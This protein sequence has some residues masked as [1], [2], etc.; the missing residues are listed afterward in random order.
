MGAVIP[1]HAI[2]IM[3]AARGPSTPKVERGTAMIYAGA[4]P[5]LSLADLFQKI[6]GAWVGKANYFYTVATVTKTSATGRR[7]TNSGDFGFQEWI[8]LD[9]DK[10]ELDL[11]S[12]LDVVDMVDELL[13]QDG[14]RLYVWSGN[15]LQVQIRVP[16][17]KDIGLFQ[18]LKPGYLH[19]IRQLDLSLRERG[20]G[21][22]EIDPRMWDAARVMRLPNTWNE[23]PDEATGQTIRKQAYFLGVRGVGRSRELWEAL[24]K[25]EG[26]FREAEGKDVV[27][28]LI[29]LWDPA[30]VTEA[31]TYYRVPCPFHPPDHKP[32]FWIY[33]NGGGWG[34]DF[35]RVKGDP[36]F[37]RKPFEIYLVKK[38]PGSDPASVGP[39][40]SRYAEY[41]RAIGAPAP[42][43]PVLDL[44]QE[45]ARER[46]QPICRSGERFFSATEVRFVRLTNGMQHL[47]AKDIQ[48]LIRERAREALGEE[49]KPHAWST[50]IKLY[51]DHAYAAFMSLVMGLPEIWEISSE[52]M[53]VELREDYTVKLRDVLNCPLRHTM[54]SRFVTRSILD[55]LIEVAL[56]SDRWWGLD[57]YRVFLKHLNGEYRIA[58]QPALLFQVPVSQAWAREYGDHRE[59]GRVLVALGLCEWDRIHVDNRRYRVLVITSPTLESTGLGQED[60]VVEPVE[61][62]NRL[63]GMITEEDL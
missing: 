52:A 11:W 47:F 51:R 29:G 15:G 46:Y 53:P 19:F 23:K 43:I 16:P 48:A 4:L 38:Y 17:F 36:D 3:E 62:G 50:I 49:G 6:D 26:D 24:E 7:K 42:R 60:T 59:I 14:E 21:F 55:R 30:E 58:F 10:I 44:V 22:K 27:A 54:G 61:E 41:C 63:V 13:P 2:T 34:V 8:P 18:S 57:D 32:S 31:S 35:H 39:D 45:W 37:R 12:P 25:H 40:D 28:T 1:R 5:G 56:E 9:I 33:K 20:L